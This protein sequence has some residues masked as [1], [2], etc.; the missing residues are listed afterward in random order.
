[1]PSGLMIQW[2][3]L[4][5]RTTD[6][7]YAPTRWIFPKSFSNTPYFAFAVMERSDG[8]IEGNFWGWI[9]NG[10]WHGSEGTFANG[11]FSNY[12]VFARW[13]AYTYRCIAIGPT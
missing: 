8:T 6:G 7:D 3:K 11:L 10:D 13:N 9:Y 12:A 5:K 4:S 2:G 1:M